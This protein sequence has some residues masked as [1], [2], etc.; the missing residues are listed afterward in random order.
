MDV[1]DL[2]LVLQ[3][4]ICI[5][6]IVLVLFKPW[7]ESRLDV[8]RQRVFAVRDELWDYAAAGNIGFDDPAYRLLRQSM[9][10]I[11]RY[12]HQLTFFRVCVTVLRIE[13]AVDSPKGSWSEDWQSALEKIRIEGTRKQLE[14]FHTA[15]M[16]LVA[17]RLIFGSPFLLMLVGLSVPLLMLRMGW[18]NVKAILKKAPFFTV[19]HVV[20]TR[21]IENEAAAAALA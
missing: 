20:D 12:A 9:N 14:E 15:A 18:L 19:S 8:F 4:S 5:G 10:G 3:S 1:K 11:I 17:S 7:S 16:Q 2:A 13:L 21:I 6:S